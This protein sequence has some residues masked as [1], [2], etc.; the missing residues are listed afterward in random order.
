MD[1]F[2]SLLGLSKDEMFADAEYQLNRNRQVRIR[3]P[4]NLPLE[5]DVRKLRNYIFDRMT[6][7]TS[8]FTFIES[9]KFTELRN[10]TCA[11]LTIYN[12][13]RGGEPARL[14]IG[15]LKEAFS[16]EWIDKQSLEFLDEI[17]KELA[18]SSKITYQSGKG[19]NLVPVIIPK[20]CLTALQILA[21][22]KIQFDVGAN[23]DNQFV[24]CNTQNS[25]VHINGTNVIADLCDKAGV[26]KSVL[27][28]T[29]QRH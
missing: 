26:N 23:P 6:S 24:F 28:A 15:E 2:L 22:P 3:K 8:E 21:D 11:R 25:K 16:G 19:T 1:K 10:L 7:L 13:R 5:S 4:A 20:D 14:L 12:A 17:E 29:G 9:S 27:T 18:S